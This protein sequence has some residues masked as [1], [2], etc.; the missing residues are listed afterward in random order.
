MLRPYREYIA[1]DYVFCLPEQIKLH[2]GVLGAC[3]CALK[4]S[5]DKIVLKVVPGELFLSKGFHAI[6][7]NGISLVQIE[8]LT[9]KLVFVED[10]E[11]LFSL[12]RE[13]IL[14]DAWVEILSDLPKSRRYSF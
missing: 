13:G 9:K 10:F 1:D 5:S 12:Q 7:D 2:T 3:Q 6:D 4:T 14:D 8:D 11:L